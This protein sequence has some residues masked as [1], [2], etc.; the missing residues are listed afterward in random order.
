MSQKEDFSDFV[1]IIILFFI[2]L[3]V[4]GFGIYTVGIMVMENKPHYEDS[5]INPV[6]DSEVDNL[7]AKTVT[8]KEAIAAEK[9]ETKTGV[10]FVP[11][12]MDKLNATLSQIRIPHRYEYGVFD[13]SEMAAY[14]EMLLEERGYHAVIC[15]SK[16]R[17][18]AWVRVYNIK[19][20]GYTRAVAIDCIPPV[21]LVEHEFYAD[22]IYENVEEAMAG[23]YPWDW[24]WWN[25]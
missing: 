5:P 11:K 24:D 22:Y 4:I 7:N 14:T 17:G 1:G 21:H 15:A 20:N 10:F 23:D 13:C 3:Q 18:H 12:T 2:A 19:D 25:I 6:V 9:K 16:E 8:R